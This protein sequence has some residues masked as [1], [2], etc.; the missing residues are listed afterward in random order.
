MSRAADAVALWRAITQAGGIQAYVTAQ[1]TERG[2]LYP[3]VER[4]GAPP[5]AEK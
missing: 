4:R 3:R 1:L 5:P 2:F